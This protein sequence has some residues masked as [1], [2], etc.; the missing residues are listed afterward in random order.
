MIRK[1]QPARMYSKEASNERRSGPGMQQIVEDLASNPSHRSRTPDV[2]SDVVWYEDDS[3]KPITK[4][5]AR[6]IIEAIKAIPTYRGTETNEL[7]AE[8]KV[9]LAGI[10]WQVGALGLMVLVILLN[11][12]WHR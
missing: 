9:Q 1:Y 2:A 7:L 11:V 3:D 6:Q 4:R 10:K 8:I 5:E 12:V